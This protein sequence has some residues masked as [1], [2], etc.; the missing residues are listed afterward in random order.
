MSSSRRIPFAAHGAIE[1]PLGLALM[2]APFLLGADP[3][4]TVISVALGVLIAGVALT[5]VGGPRAS[6]LPLS[7]HESYDQALALGG[8]GGAA[9]LA[10]VGQSAVAVA[11]LVCS[12]ALLVLSAATRYSGR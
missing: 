3:A 8:V 1:F 6:T 4:G 12:L 2:A 7:A 9:A 10:V 11:V 5:S